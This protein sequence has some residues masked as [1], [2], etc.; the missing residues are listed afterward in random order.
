MLEAAVDFPDEEVFRKKSPRARVR[1]L[2][3]C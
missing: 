1:G 2:E 3:S